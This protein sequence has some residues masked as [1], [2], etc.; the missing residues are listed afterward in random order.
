METVQFS[1]DFTLS[2]M[3]N[4]EL[5]PDGMVAAV[6][7]TRVHVGGRKTDSFVIKMTVF[8]VSSRVSLS[9]LQGHLT[10]H[11]LHVAHVLHKPANKRAFA[12]KTRRCPHRRNVELQPGLL[13][14]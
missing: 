13:D 3:V 10:A 8:I 9:S 2:N 14:L 7:V 1:T 4:G 12:A 6:K 5:T 11:H